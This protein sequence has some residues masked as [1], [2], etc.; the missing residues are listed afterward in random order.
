MSLSLARNCMLNGP[1]ILSALAIFLEI[2]LI[3]LMVSM[4]NF[5][6]GKTMVASPEWTPANSTCSEMAYATISPLAAT[7]STSISLAFSMNSLT[8]TGCS[9]DTLAAIWRK[10]SSCSELDTTFM[11]APDNTYDGLISTGNPTI[12][13]NLCTSSIVE[14]LAHLGWSTPMLSSRDENLSLSSALSIII[15]EVPRMGTCWRWSFMA[16]LL[17]ICPPTET[18]TPCGFSSSMMS[19]T[20][21]RV[22]SSK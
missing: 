11:A 13:M 12:S 1:E 10:W 20:L 9:F 16:R 18:T 8:T 15:G 4:Y 3:L 7:A 5:C 17:G 22:S 19:S 6:G 2:F 14:S 21:S